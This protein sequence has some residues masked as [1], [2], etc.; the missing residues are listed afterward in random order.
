MNRIY[1]FLSTRIGEL[2]FGLI[3]GLSYF[4]IVLNFIMANTHVGGSL[5]ALFTAPAII[6]GIALV[7][8]KLL[9]NWRQNEQYKNVISFFA[10]NFVIF[11]ISIFFAI[12]FFVNFL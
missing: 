9:R 2:I 7:F 3:C 1:Q 6:C 4:V 11:I 5:L 12:D 10:L 8:I